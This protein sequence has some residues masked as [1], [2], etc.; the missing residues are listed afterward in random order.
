MPQ[1][2][3]G[4]PYSAGQKRCTRRGP[5]PIPGEHAFMILERALLPVRPEQEA[6]FEPA[7]AKAKPARCPWVACQ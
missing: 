4:T 6:D 1:E 2:A 3:Q 7:F 5:G